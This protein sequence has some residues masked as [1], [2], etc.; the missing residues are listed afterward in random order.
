MPRHA[1]RQARLVGAVE[2]GKNF[3]DARLQLSRHGGR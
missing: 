1:D 2:A 3:V